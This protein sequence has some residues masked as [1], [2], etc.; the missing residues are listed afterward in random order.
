MCERRKLIVQT[1]RIL[2]FALRRSSL[3]NCNIEFH[4]KSPIQGNNID[5]SSEYCATL[6]HLS[7]ASTITTVTTTMTSSSMF[8]TFKFSVLCLVVLCFACAPARR[9][10]GRQKPKS[11]KLLRIGPLLSL[12]TYRVSPVMWATI[13]CK[14]AIGANSAL[15]WSV[16]SWLSSTTAHVSI[17]YRSE[18]VGTWSSYWSRDSVSVFS[19]TPFV[20]RAMLLDAISV[21]LYLDLP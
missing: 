7:T 1:A 19:S 4:V 20:T 21:W 10:N 5:N 9:M 8:S 11:P 3:R 18:T 6:S 13:S 12:E 14:R 17:P 2:E 16:T 15:V